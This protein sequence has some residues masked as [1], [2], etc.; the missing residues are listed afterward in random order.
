MADKKFFIQEV[1]EPRRN[2]STELAEKYDDTP[3]SASPTHRGGKRI[4]TRMS[5]K[6]SILVTFTNEEHAHIVS[7][8]EYHGFS[9]NQTM[10]MLARREY[11]TLFPDGIPV[12]VAIT[13]KQLQREEAI[14]KTLNW[15]KR[16]ATARRKKAGKKR[17]AKTSLEVK[18]EWKERQKLG[19]EAVKKRDTRMQ[20]PESELTASGL[21][22]RKNTALVNRM[23]LAKEAKLLR[24]RKI[25]Q[26]NSP[27][28][29]DKQ[30]G[31][32]LAE[33][34]EWEFEE[35]DQPEG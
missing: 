13:K 18:Q 30:T 20:K 16:L 11:D 8:S 6:K 35:S 7:I 29:I 32:S 4:A 17:V 31:L 1:F 33:S 24:E 21:L 23:K 12:E 5:R 22:K 10:R 19:I 26:A 14:K 9:L 2:R 25:R 15:K 27:D 34:T 3:G 28:N